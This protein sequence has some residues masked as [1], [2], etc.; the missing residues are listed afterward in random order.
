[1]IARD[2]LG[3]H[4][5]LLLL[6]LRDREGTTHGYGAYVNALGAAVLGELVAQGRVAL[7]PEGKKL[8]VELRDA[9][10][11][12]DEA[13]DEALARVAAAKKRAQVA[14]WVSRCAGMKQLKH[15]VARDLCRRGILK[16]EEQTI[17]LIFRRAV[18]PEVDP[19]PERAIVER[20]RRAAFGEAAAPEARA[21]MLLSLCASIDL[22]PALLDKAQVKAR[23][24]Q[25]AALVKDEPLG[26]AV[27]ELIQAAATAAAVSA[28]T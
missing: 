26:K 4:H 27:R 15:R 19:R 28:A 6:A 18:Y 14:A 24:K 23:K 12:G 7:A 17:L 13:L 20:L 5:E 1:M 10:P 16:A 3:L 2:D 8:F 21:L 11:L 25:I 9:R 22:L